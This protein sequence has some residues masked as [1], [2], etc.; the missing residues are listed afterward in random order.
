LVVGL[1]AAFVG[2]REVTGKQKP[3]LSGLGGVDRLRFSAEF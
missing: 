3:L 1:P 2:I